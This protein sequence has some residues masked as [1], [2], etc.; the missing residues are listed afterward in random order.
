[1]KELL[2]EVVEDPECGYRARAL[3]AEKDKWDY[4]QVHIDEPVSFPEA[5]KI[6]GQTMNT[7]SYYFKPSALKIRKGAKPE[8]G[9]KKTPADFADSPDAKENDISLN[10]TGHFVVRQR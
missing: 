3:G 9:E 4:Y 10:L 2:F 6:L 5:K 1:M 7:D 8:P